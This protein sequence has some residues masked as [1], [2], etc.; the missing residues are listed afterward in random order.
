MRLAPRSKNACTASRGSMWNRRMKSRG[1]IGPI[2]KSATSM[3]G[4]RCADLD[5]ELLVVRGVAAEVDLHA[6]V[7]DDVAGERLRHPRVVDAVA[8]ADVIDGHR[9][10][11]QA[12]LLVRLPRAQLEHREAEVG[13]V[14]RRRRGGMSSIRTLRSIISRLPSDR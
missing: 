5:E 8:K 4:K 12:V 2:G 6:V 7:L 14:R 9:R 13:Q 3:S 1:S 10:D 11:A